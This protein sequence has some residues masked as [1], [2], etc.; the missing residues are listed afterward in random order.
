MYD[1]HDCMCCYFL[2]KHIKYINIVLFIVFCKRKNK[3]HHLQTSSTNIN[4]LS[5]THTHTQTPPS[6]SPLDTTDNKWIGEKEKIILGL[7]ND[8]TQSENSP[9]FSHTCIHNQQGTKAKHYKELKKKTNKQTNS[10]CNQESSKFR[11]F[12]EQN[13]NK[14][15]QRI[16]TTS[17]L[18]HTEHH[19]LL[20]LYRWAYTFRTRASF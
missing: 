5:H 2:M 7:E 18:F 10:Q 14:S 6:P 19:H 20:V 16:F 13:T 3:T 1:T 8:T 11:F 4:S 17:L 12:K 9:S 15:K